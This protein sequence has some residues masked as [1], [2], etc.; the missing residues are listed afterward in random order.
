MPERYPV[1]RGK[2]RRALLRRFPY[3]VYFVA[4]RISSASSPACTR[5]ATQ[6][7]GGS[8]A[9]LTANKRIKLSRRSA[10]DLTGAGALAAYP[11]CVGRPC[12]GH[13]TAT[14]RGGRPGGHPRW[15]GSPRGT[16]RAA[17]LSMPPPIVMLPLRGSTGTSSS[18]RLRRRHC[19]GRVAPGH[20]RGGPGRL[21][22]RRVASRP[23][24]RHCR[25]RASPLGVLRRYP[26][27]PVALRVRRTNERAIA[28]Y[29]RAGFTVTGAAPRR[30]PPATPCPTTAWSLRRAE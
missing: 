7:V 20:E 30:C 4:T 22:L 8:A 6:G 15:A 10:G 13:F 21:P 9:K 18:R 19:L 28:C 24:H 3:A 26:G 16:C 2:A 29:R 1:V 17:V 25:H 11:R 12:G 23:R 5:G 27:L 14:R